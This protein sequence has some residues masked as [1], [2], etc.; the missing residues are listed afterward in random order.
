MS[1]PTL[2]VAAS[3]TSG[4]LSV[5][6]QSRVLPNQ[7]EDYTVPRCVHGGASAPAAE[8]KM[9]PAREQDNHPQL[10]LGPRGSIACVISQTI[11]T[12]WS[13]PFASSSKSNP[14]ATTSPQSTASPP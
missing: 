6:R 4:V 10:P 11:G 1:S 2:D 7:P 3:V 5:M 12:E 9:C 14:P 13:K 8:R